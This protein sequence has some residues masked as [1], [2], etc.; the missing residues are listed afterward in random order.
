MT[1]LLCPASS[2][3][4]VII[5][6]RHIS[7]HSWTSPPPLSQPQPQPL[8]CMRGSYCIGHVPGVRATWFPFESLTNMLFQIPAHLPGREATYHRALFPHRFEMVAQLL[9]RPGMIT[10][11]HH[12]QYPHI[13]LFGRPGSTL[14]RTRA[15]V[16]KRALL[17]SIL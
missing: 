12:S 11:A 10:H 8:R 6:Q 5:K 1:R 4:P 2:G 15:A 3:Y 9:V 17:G 7:K 13:L 14:P 16:T